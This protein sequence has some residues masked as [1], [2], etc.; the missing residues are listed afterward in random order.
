[1][2]EDDPPPPAE[3]LEQLDVMTVVIAVIA[4]VVVVIVVAATTAQGD[5]GLKRRFVRLPLAM[6]VASLLLH[7]TSS[8]MSICDNIRESLNKDNETVMSM[9]TRE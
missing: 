4:V 1:M 6:L 5:K 3:A 2:D 9:N 8:S 7:E